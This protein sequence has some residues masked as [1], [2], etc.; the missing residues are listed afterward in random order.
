MID[1]EPL[2]FLAPPQEPGELGR[3]G[4]YR[5]LKLLGAGGMGLVLQAEDP[6]LKRAVALK[7]MRPESAKSK[8]ARQRFLR[9]AQ[10]ITAIEHPHI[11][12][13]YQVGE[14]RGVP[15]LAMPLLKG[16][17]L[18]ARLKREAN[19]PWP[20]PCASAGRSPRGWRPPTSMA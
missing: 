12:H 6:L 13:I 18:E 15:F 2:D 5:V 11:V 10:A 7:V 4:P 20:I 8:E 14:D 16:E 1:D 9:E 17:P 3:L 19:C